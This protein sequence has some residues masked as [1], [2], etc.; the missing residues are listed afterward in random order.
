MT[1]S[2]PMY[3]YLCGATA[4]LS[5]YHLGH[6]LGELNTLPCVDST[7][8]QSY[9]T[10]LVAPTCIPMSALEYSTANAVLALG[11][12]LG[13]LW[14]GRA[15]DKYGR[16][17]T[18][19]VLNIP[20]LIASLMMAF[21]TNLPMLII[22]RLLAG[23]GTG[24]GST[25]APMY[26]S[27]IA[28]IA[29]RGLLGVFSVLGLAT[30][31]FVT[32]L[33]SF[34][35]SDPQYWRLTI[36]V[37]AFFC[38][39]QLALLLVVVESPVYLRA[40]GRTSEAETVMQRMGAHEELAALDSPQSES[41]ECKDAASGSGAAGATV[42]LSEF[43]TSRAHRKSLWILVL[44]HATQ[45]LSGINVYFSFAFSILTLILPSAYAASL[46][47]VIFD[48][49][50]VLLNFVPGLLLER[51]GRRPLIL[52]SMFCMA[53]CAAVF[54]LA[55]KLGQPYVAL[56]AFIL[57]VTTFA[58]GLSSV[59]FIYTAEVVEPAAV[60]VASQVAL[61]ANNLGNFII[62]FAFPPLLRQ[63]GSYVFVILAVYLL[64]MGAIGLRILPETK[65]KTPAQVVAELRSS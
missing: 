10:F 24:G 6:H 56:V 20:L 43:L 18:M 58:I 9:P 37:G 35:W 17:R 23:L 60:G 64:V 38:V 33:V 1:A 39:L 47:L 22:G 19:Q 27:E 16:V 15:C 52:A 8:T 28:P 2:S 59:P 12:A 40:Q 62:L 7:P 57:A 11:G 61:V 48:L 50:Y 45:Q 44:S 51:Y 63:I 5:M 21:A 36:L 30:G 46:F 31:L 34:L 13:A 32:A 4:A 65:G 3:L 29:K 25:L 42:S 41:K 54:T 53:I 26:I 49:Y 55:E 14:A